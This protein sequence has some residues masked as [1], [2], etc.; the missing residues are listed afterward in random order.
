MRD[1]C[2][3]AVDEANFWH[4]ESQE[5]FAKRAKLTMLLD[6]TDAVMTRREFDE[7]MEYST[8]LPSGTTIGK[9]WKCHARNDTWWLGEYCE[10][11]LV[12]MVDIKWRRI[13]VVD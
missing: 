4:R 6:A 2:A 12:G 1:A 3:E 8:S 5:W 11:T 13:H 7:L 10:T 9:I